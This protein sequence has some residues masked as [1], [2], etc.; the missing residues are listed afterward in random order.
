MRKRNPRKPRAVSTLLT[1]QQHE[2]IIIGP[3]MHLAHLNNNEDLQSFFENAQ[4][5]LLDS[6]SSSEQIVLHDEVTK[7]LQ[8]AFNQLDRYIGIQ[9]GMALIRAIEFIERGVATGEGV[10]IVD[11][12]A[13][14]PQSHNLV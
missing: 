12:A 4:K 14:H 3:R 6:M 5:L 8:A 1:P 13:S 11:L 2:R 10:E 7:E 9:H